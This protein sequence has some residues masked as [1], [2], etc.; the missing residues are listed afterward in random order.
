M[1][2]C[3]LQKMTLLDYP[4]KVACTVFTGGCNFRCPFCHNASLVLHQDKQRLVLTEDFFSFLRKRQGILD[5]VCITGGEPLLQAD[6]ADF[7]YQVKSL[8]FAVKLDTNGSFPQRLNEL[9]QEGLLDYVAMDVKSSPAH[10]REAA[11]IEP[12]DFAAIKQ[13]IDFLLSEPVDYEFRTTV[14]KGLHDAIVLQDAASL[15]AGAKR[16]YLQK[17]EDSGDLIGTHLSAFT[18]DEMQRF[19]QVVSPFVHFAALR[20]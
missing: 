18:D 8:G 1:K 5:G 19:L 13:C 4:G 9:V 7:L 6:I 14:V 20:G 3:G 16:Y 12:F 10:Y 2:I 17:F 11:G 15:I